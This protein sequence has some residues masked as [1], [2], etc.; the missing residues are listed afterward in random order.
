M[1]YTAY[2]YIKGDT[3]VS[4]LFLGWSETEFLDTMAIIDIQKQE[5]LHYSEKTC[6]STTLSTTWA[7]LGPNQ[8]LHSEKV[9]VTHLSYSMAFA[10][11]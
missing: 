10:K 7:A 6:P 2:N 3:R 5:K 9:A 1:L 8:S 11:N 4:F